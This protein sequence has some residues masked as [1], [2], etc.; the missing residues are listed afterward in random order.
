MYLTPC[1]NLPGEVN[2]IKIIIVAS[3]CKLQQMPKKASGL[4]SVNMTSV[5]RSSQ[6]AN[7][8]SVAA[9]REGG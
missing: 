8:Y 4:L 1:T 2:L 5:L 6:L 9:K 3:S 7:E